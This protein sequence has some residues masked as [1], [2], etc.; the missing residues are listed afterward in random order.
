MHYCRPSRS[1]ANILRNIIAP[2]LRNIIAPLLRDNIVLPVT[3]AVPAPAAYSRGRRRVTAHPLRVLTSHVPP[4]PTPPRPPSPPR[5]RIEPPFGLGIM[6]VTALEMLLGLHSPSLSL[7]LSLSLRPVPP[8][9]CSRSRFPAF[10]PRAAAA[11]SV[12]PTPPRS[13]VY[14]L[15]YGLWSMVWSMVYGL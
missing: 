7:P 2:L 9:G 1:T 3:S 4:T 8:T 15:V 10:A 12:P 13:M 5:R 14:G 6:K 11:C